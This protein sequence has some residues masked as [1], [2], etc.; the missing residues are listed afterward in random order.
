MMCLT[1]EISKEV[2]EKV[3]K[4]P[5]EIKK[6]LECCMPRWVANHWKS[7][8]SKCPYIE[9]SAQCRGTLLYDALTYIQ[10]LEAQVPKWID[11]EERLPTLED[12]SAN[13]LVICVC[14]DEDNKPIAEEV[15]AW[16]VDTVRRMA[17]CF[18]HWMPMN[19]LFSLLPELPKEDT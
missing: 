14:R 11:V 8:S 13:E 3:M 10:Q 17:P 15:H 1:C 5:E 7:C 12:A 2:S 9:L 19:Q 18:T 6:G 16:H 4:T